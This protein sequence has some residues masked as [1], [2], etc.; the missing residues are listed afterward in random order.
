MAC[1]ST[2]YSPLL[3]DDEVSELVAGVKIGEWDYSKG[4]GERPGHGRTLFRLEEMI[5]LSTPQMT[6]ILQRNDR[7][8]TS[9]KNEG[10]DGKTYL[11]DVMIRDGSFYS[12]SGE[13]SQR[14]FE[15]VY[16]KTK[17]KLI[18]CVNED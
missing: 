6:I 18:A 14:L 5:S 11:V 9:G 4:W 8:H 7:F 16:A 15:K 2:H 1:D 13:F 3:H 17:L 10:V 12:R